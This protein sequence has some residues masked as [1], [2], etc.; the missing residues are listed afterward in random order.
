ME[1][2][3]LVYS[4]KPEEWLEGYDLYYKLYRRKGTYLKA[5]LFVAALLLFIQQVW[6]D[7][8][9]IMGWICAAV[10][11]GAIVC[12]VYLTP[13][14]ERGTTERALETIKGEKYEL[15]LTEDKL[16]VSAIVPEG[17]E[18]PDGKR[19]TVIDIRDKSVKI[20]E[21]EKIIGLFSKDTSV[22]VPKSELNEYDVGVL[23]ETV[24]R[25]K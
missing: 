23:K 13:K 18:T 19:P 11:I 21:T 16:T 17:E 6:L 20:I 22:V 4:V 9:F 12:I 5:A 15:L 8:Y 2:L 10:C 25:A 24:E 3:K 14:M 1:K 7:P